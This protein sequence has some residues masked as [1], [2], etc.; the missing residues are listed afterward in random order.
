MKTN[1]YIKILLDNGLN[2]KTISKLNESQIKVL[3]DD[4]ALH[5][6]VNKFYRPNG[7]EIH[8]VGIKTDMDIKDE[9]EQ[10]KVA[11]KYLRGN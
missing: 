11:I 1:K 6:T 5:I 10:L 2:V 8:K 4:S 7:K 9:R 3:A